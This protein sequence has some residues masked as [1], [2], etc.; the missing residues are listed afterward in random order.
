MKFGNVA[1]YCKGWYRHRS[2]KVNTMW[3]DMLHCINA[4]GWSL[5]SKEDVVEWCLFR[6]D[7]LCEDENFPHKNQL[8][9][10]YFWKETND[11]IR[12]DEWHYHEGLD[13]K[14]A[15]IL[16]YR[17]II[18]NLEG[19]YFNE[20]L[21]KPNPEVLPL[22]YG[23]AYYSEGK[24]TVSHEPEYTFAD[25]HCD[26]IEKIN[27]MFPD[28]IEQDIKEGEFEYQEGWIRGKEWQNV[29]VLI[30]SD[31]LL[32]CEEVN[33]SGYLLNHADYNKYK[34]DEFLDLNIYAHTVNF[35]NNKT[36]VC[37]VKKEIKHWE[38]GDDINYKLMSILNETD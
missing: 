7:A 9:L 20:L 4:D 30:G 11:I 34:D 6:M 2:N 22:H 1:L 18:S 12:R 38:W 25:M 3:M 31:S 8:D 28:H 16:H 21:V 35:D 15:I 24:Y 14:D 29:V 36:Y 37:H 27:K 5:W 13:M 32:D 26:V 17:N 23:Q 19:K 33:I 10:H